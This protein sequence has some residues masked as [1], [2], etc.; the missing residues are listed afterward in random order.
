MR[1]TDRSQF[2]KATWDANEAPTIGF[3]D[4]KLSL[5]SIELNFKIRML[6]SKRVELVNCL[7]QT[8]AES[9]SRLGTVGNTRS[10]DI[11][12]SASFACTYL[13]M[14]CR[15]EFPPGPAAERVSLGVP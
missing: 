13:P 5:L 11:T 3:G 7:I 6:F 1:F 8:L 14:P 9:N 4:S 10:V 15:C 12:E 2:S